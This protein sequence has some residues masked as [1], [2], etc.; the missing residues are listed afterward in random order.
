MSD[1]RRIFL[2]WGLPAGKELS[3]VLY[4]L[5]M[6]CILVVFCTELCGDVPGEM[7]RPQEVKVAESSLSGWAWKQGL[8]CRLLCAQELQG[9]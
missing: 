7:K 4:I 5:G 9:A 8:Q 3:A 1:S 2:P 6:K